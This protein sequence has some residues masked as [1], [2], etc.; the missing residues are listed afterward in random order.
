MLPPDRQEAVPDRS[1]AF[2]TLHVAQGAAAL[3]KALDT[4]VGHPAEKLDQIV[5]KGL[6]CPTGGIDRAACAGSQNGLAPAMSECDQAGTLKV[7]FG[8]GPHL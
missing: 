2:R 1:R 5:V 4:C 6:R 3:G 8:V 7:S